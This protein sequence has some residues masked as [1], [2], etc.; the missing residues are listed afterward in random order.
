M[1]KP[2]PPFRAVAW[3]YND[4]LRVWYECDDAPMPYRV[5]RDLL[6]TRDPRHIFAQRRDD[7]AGKTYLVHKPARF[8]VTA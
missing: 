8:W 5:A 1:S 6:M 3:H 2:I 7:K 4:K